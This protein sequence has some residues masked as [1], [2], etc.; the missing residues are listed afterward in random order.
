MT[1]PRVYIVGTDTAVGK[2]TVVAALI[3]AAR[4]RGLLWLPFKPAQSGD[5]S[6]PRDDASRLAAAAGF[7]A[8]AEIAPLRFDRP[9]APGLAEDPEPFLH[10]ATRGPRDSTPLIPI[11]DEIARSLIALEARY[12]PAATLIEGA[13]GFHVPMPGGSWQASW[14]RALAPR[15]LLVGRAGLGAINHAL[16][17]LDALRQ[18]EV[19]PVGFCLVETAP[20]DAAN[21]LNPSVI[22]RA[23]RVPYLG[24]MRHGATS[25]DAEVFDGIAA[26]LPVA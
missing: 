1:P 17:T 6:E 7:V 12:R 24:T 18:A 9:I 22:E 4:G 19:T 20:P 26:Q 3:A 14:I 10:T 25:V 23:S 15:V 21:P 16:L 8:P 11:L 13:G 2:T 5:P